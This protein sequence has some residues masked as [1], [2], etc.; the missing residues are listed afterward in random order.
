MH[1]ET[2]NVYHLYNRGNN[3]QPIFFRPEN[4]TYFLNKIKIQLSPFCEILCWCLMPSHFHLMI[5]AKNEGCKE[6]KTFGGK[7]MQEL[8]YRIG[9]L[10]SSY[11]QAINKQNHTTGSLFQQKTKAKLLTYDQITYGS[12]GL[13]TSYIVSCVHYIHQNAWLAGLV[14][15]IEDWNY[16]S[17][18]EYIG[19]TSSQLC[20]RELLYKLTGYDVAHFYR[21][22]YGIIEEHLL[23]GIF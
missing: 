7:P 23:N 13:R 18:P 2:D 1:F 10:L 5:Y 11:S 20:N 14:K 19:T 17:F 9:V 6:R 15:K 22:S 16:S 8:P 12:S 21:D 3:K 4:Y